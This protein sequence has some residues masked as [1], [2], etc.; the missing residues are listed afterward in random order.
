AAAAAS[1]GWAGSTPAASSASST[2]MATDHS[3]AQTG[4]ASS[5]IGSS[6]ARLSAARRPIGEAGGA[7]TTQRQ[8]RRTASDSAAAI[9]GER[10]VVEAT[11]TR[12]SDPIQPGSAGPGT[13][14]I[15]TFAPGPATAATSPATVAPVP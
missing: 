6:A 2:G 10:P 11:T 15:G 7:T 1:Y 5:A 13:D 14:R 9:S 3:R 8:P 4:A 12:S